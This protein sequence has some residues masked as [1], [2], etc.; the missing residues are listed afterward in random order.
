MGSSTPVPQRIRNR[1]CPPS[2]SHS[3]VAR[4]P[5]PWPRGTRTAGLHFAPEQFPHCDPSG[6]DRE[7]PCS[8]KALWH[9]APAPARFQRE[10]ESVRSL[11]RQPLGIY[12][13]SSFA[14]ILSKSHRNTD[15]ISLV[16]GFLARITPLS[17]RGK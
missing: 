14:P 17:P 2:R 15:A 7:P 1:S 9:L 16:R 4:G 12:F 10:Q 8:D 13:V 6:T 3:H 11:M 5:Q